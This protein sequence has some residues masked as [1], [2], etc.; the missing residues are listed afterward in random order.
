MEAYYETLNIDP[1]ASIKD[2]KTAY[3][4]LAKRF[5][6][7]AAGRK[8]D[9]PGRFQEIHEAY[10]SLVE[11]LESRLERAE[12]EVQNQGR[13]GWSFEGVAGQ[14]ADVIYILRVSALAAEKGLNLALPWEKEDACP[15]CLGLGHT[16]K[17]MFGG[18]HL[19][20]VPCLKCQGQGVVRRKSTLQINLSPGMILQGELHLTGLGHYKPSQASRGDLVI[21]LK[22]ETDACSAD[23]RTY[24]TGA[25]SDFII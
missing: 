24:K 12:P 6:P 19:R 25:I 23:N 1:A 13:S 3:R 17:P 4:R 9:D 22:I 7:D 20:K 10:H 16:L 5:H 14:G 21:R 15:R 8:R 2:I 11:R 18:P